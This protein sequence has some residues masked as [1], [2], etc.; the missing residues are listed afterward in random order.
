MA[1]TISISNVIPVDAT[2]NEFIVYGSIVLTGSYPAHGDTLDFSKFSQ[3][4]SN[5]L[6]N[7]IDIAEFPLAGTDPSGY[8]LGFAPGTTLANGLLTIFN[9]AATPFS[10]GAY[11]APLLAAVINFQAWFKSFS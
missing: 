3:I 8:F 9:G 11:S 6:L 10:T 7:W 5:A 4:P 2:Q 1:A